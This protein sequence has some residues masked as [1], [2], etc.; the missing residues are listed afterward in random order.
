MSPALTFYGRFVKPLL[1]FIVALMA[2][3]F[4]SPLWV[5]ITILLYLSNRGQVFF[6]QVRPGYQGKSFQIIKFITM[7]DTRG[8]DGEWLP[9]QDR[10]TAIGRWLRKTS[11]DELPQLIN[12]LKGEMSIVGPRPL[13]P[14]YLDL[15]SPEQARRHAVR[16]GLTGWAQVN[17]R[18]AITWKEKFILD[19]RYVD[20]Q[21]FFLDLKILFLTLKQVMGAQDIN[22][23]GS[24]TAEKFNGSN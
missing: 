3:I 11:L 17:G 12:V 19:V 1:D 2:L 24:A 16:P 23:P 14:E 15:Y 9:D 8:T 18:N 4:F 10:L 6:K 22:T 7:N 5:I 21:S 20:R 13:L